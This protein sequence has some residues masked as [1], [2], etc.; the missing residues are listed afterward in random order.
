MDIKLS[1]AKPPNWDK[2]VEL[3]GVEWGGVVVTYGDTCYSAGPISQ[4]LIV[5]ETVHMGQQRRPKKWWKRYYKDPTFRVEQET[6]AYQAQYQYLKS[7][8]KDR[9]LLFKIH[10]KLACDLSGKVYG[11]CINYATAFKR[12]EGKT[13]RGDNA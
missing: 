3:F 6:E 10:D 1:N 8:V 12:I 11:N 9:N 2:L 5:H 4:D 7:V 13:W